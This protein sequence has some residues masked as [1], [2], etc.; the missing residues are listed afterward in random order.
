MAGER[1]VRIKFT[2][3]SAVLKGSAADVRQIFQNL[4]ADENDARGAGEK[5]ADAQKQ[6]ADKMRT[7]MASISAAAD[8]LADSLGPEMVQAIEA[9]G[10][11][12]EDEVQRF[13][14]LG[15]TLDDIKRDSDL[16]AQGMKELDDAARMSSGSIGDGFQK[17]TKNVDQSRS[18]MANFAG[19]AAQELPL[20]AGSFGP[21]NMAISQF[22]EY[23]VEGNVNLKNI[24][25]T[26]GPMAGVAAAIAYVNSQLEMM[27][28]KEAFREDRVEAF[29]EVINQSGDAVANLAEHLREVG[30]IEATTWGNAGNPFADATEDIT[31]KVLAAGLTV[32]QYSRILVGGAAELDRW[33]AAQIAA[34][35]ELDPELM[36][37]LAQAAS[38]YEG[39][40]ARLATS[41]LFFAT[42]QKD[43]NEAVREFVDQQDPIAAFPEEFR[44]MAQ[45]LADGVAPA[46]DDV[47]RVTA[48]LNVTTDQAISIASGY[49]TTLADE[50]VAALEAVKEAEEAAEQAQRDLN[51]AQMAAIDAGFAARDAQDN[52]T[53]SLER[54]AKAVDDP[55]TGV[56]ELRQ[57]QDDAAQAAI[58]MALANQ[59]NAENLAA[60]A[61]APLD[62]AA[63]N[64][65]LIRSLYDTALALAP[66]S[67]L[68]TQ[69]IEYIGTLQSQVPAQ[70]TTAVVA[71]TDDALGRIGGVKA[72]VDEL[73]E[74]SAT[75]STEAETATALDKVTTLTGAVDDLDGRII[76]LGM[77]LTG[78]VDTIARL[79][80]LRREL[81]LTID[82]ANEADRA[83]GRVAG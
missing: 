63:S 38:D 21:L 80:T 18:V 59:A 46:V 83:V 76:S 33:M 71:N 52:Y 50:Q 15:L 69:L 11:S 32:D 1:E 45:A 28:A 47:N 55:I 2:G 17:V 8:V 34:G 19:N 20:V 61:G 27:K 37:S 53:T 16:L 26:A 4:I 44:R 24:A 81:Q 60:L 39:S 68:R 73:G 14:K 25:A 77:D 23:G 7:E 57:A 13:Q 40:A 42:T 51:D 5:L 35:N 36:I 9:T 10:R 56:D 3:D 29:A 66:D 48:G 43:V 54:L 78:D 12:V 22:V 62:A 75:T 41:N 30:K 64:Q 65:V 31:K 72:A 49:A 58:G 67:P 6:V 82:K 70:V 74:T 79:Q